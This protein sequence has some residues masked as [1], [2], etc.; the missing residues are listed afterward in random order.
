MVIL[1]K[2]THADTEHRARDIGP[3][4]LDGT[5]LF[6]DRR[7]RGEPGIAQMMFLGRQAGQHARLTGRPER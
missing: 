5:N 3:E 6:A 1:V 7:H 4:I 2:F